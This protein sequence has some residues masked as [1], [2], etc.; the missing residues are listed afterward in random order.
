LKKNVNKLLMGI[1]LKTDTGKTV[2]IED[3]PFSSGGQGGVYRFLGS[4]S[5]MV[6]KIFYHE[7]KERLV[8]AKKLEP[9]ILFMIRNSPIK[10]SSQSIQNTLVWPIELL[11]KNGN[12]VGFSMPFAGDAKLNESPIK[13]TSLCKEELSKKIKTL[14]QWDKFDRSLPNSIKTRLQ[15]CYNIARSV[16]ALHS[17]QNYILVDFKPDNILINSNAWMSIIDLDSIQISRGNKTLFL[18]EAFTEEYIPPEWQKKMPLVPKTSKNVSWDRFCY[19][20]L[21]YQ[22]LLGIHP[23]TASH[24]KFHST[25]EFIREGLFPNGKRKNELDY[26]P[27]VHNAFKTLPIEVQT[28][29]LKCFED[30]YHNSLIRPSLKEWA[31]TIVNILQKPP[32]IISFKANKIIRNNLDPI[33]LSWKVENAGK[34]LLNGK[35]IKNKKYI[36]VLPVKDTTYTLE[37]INEN[38][39]VKSQIAIKID[40]RPPAIIFF[41]TNKLLLTNH[42][43]AILSWKVERA[44]KIEI[45]TIGNVTNKSSCKV[46]P[47]DDIDYY[48]RVTGYFGDIVEEKL[49][50]KTSKKVPS[51]KSFKSNIT[52]RTN[53][54]KVYLS[55]VVDDAHTLYIE[56][57]GDVSKLKNITVD[58]R[59]DTIYKLKAI[60][61][62]GIESNSQ[63]QVTVSKAP[64]V[65]ELFEVSPKMRIDNTPIQLHWKVK[66]AEKITLMP[67]GEEL[68]LKGSKNISPYRNIE[69]ILKCET[70]FGIVITKKITAYVSKMPPV[71]K[72][73]KFSKSMV[74]ENSKVQLNWEVEG[75]QKIWIN[76]NSITHHKGN[77]VV[78]IKKELKYYLK[79]ETMFG[80]LANE[81][82]LIHVL[83]KPKLMKYKY[84][85]KLKK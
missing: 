38:K 47:K 9:R 31:D 43:P 20:V 74:Q 59:K 29:F 13:L 14:N 71:I 16:D 52:H 15:L 46:S 80:S 67:T 73:F 55:C 39:S 70:L 2:F 49:T 78:K 48:L 30:G 11:Y 25:S 36:D 85:L 24:K 34:I 61:Y 8:K 79:A 54:S 63:L 22:L 40:S 69:Y 68:K 4:R 77:M 50:I 65:I 72:V 76:G 28:L 33:H 18:A 23:F 12:F 62:F 81:I 44:K 32:K 7:T 75:A 26:I 53:D 37:V 58:P 27:P 5:K 60:S 1:Q 64:P 41:K 57:V 83:K 66:N 56:G 6:A 35:Q 19:A 10:N 82:A 51:I 17:T 45:N 3:K 21:A 84:S 42:L